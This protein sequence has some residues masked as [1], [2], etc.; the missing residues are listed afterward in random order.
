MLSL[1]NNGKNIL[2]LYVV[3]IFRDDVSGHLYHTKLTHDHVNLTPASTMS[4]RLAAQVTFDELDS[5]SFRDG[6]FD[7]QGR[8]WDFSSQQVIFFSLF[9]QQV[10]LFKSKLQQIYY[11]IFWKNNTLKSEKM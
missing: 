10:I 1:Q 8:G 2:W 7:I 3:K 11:L 6:P 4:V 5:E 9:A